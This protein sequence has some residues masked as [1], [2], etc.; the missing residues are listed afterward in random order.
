MKKGLV[1]AV[2]GQ[3]GAGKTTYA[4][5]L[6]E[7]FGLRYASSGGLFRKLAEE[8]GMDV[9]QFQDFVSKNPQ[10]DYEIDKRSAELLSIS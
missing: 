1:I 9:I 2:S 5:K 3:V 7:T 8:Y 6:A 4:K 10:I